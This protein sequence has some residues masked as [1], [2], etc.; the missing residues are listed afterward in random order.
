MSPAKPKKAGSRRPAQSVVAADG[1]AARLDRLEQA[2]ESLATRQAAEFAGLNDAIER[3][4]RRAS[5]P[6]DV[7]FSGDRGGEA[8]IL[9]RKYRRA[10]ADAERL[11][12]ELAEVRREGG[13]GDEAKILKRKYRRAQADA[14]QLRGE[15]AEARRELAAVR[16]ART[17]ISKQISGNIGH[18]LRRLLLRVPGVRKRL[19][20]SEQ[21]REIAIILGS[22]LFDPDWYLETY[23]DIAQ[24]GFDPAM[25]YLK[26]GWLETRDP[27][28]DFSTSGYLKANPDVA[29]SGAN[30]LL[31]YIE[32]GMGEGRSVGVGAQPQVRRSAEKFDPPA[33]CLQLPPPAVRPMQ[34]RRSHALGRAQ[35]GHV[36]LDGVVIGSSLASAQV[37]EEALDR[38]SR[39]ASTA[40]ELSPE[41][42]PVAAQQADQ[43]LP[44]LAD[45][46]FV[47]HLTM[48]MHWAGDPMRPRVVRAL[49]WTA[50][51]GLRLVGEGL[52]SAV[53]D[54]IDLELYTALHPL[55]LVFTSPNGEIVGGDV[56]AFPSLCRG[57]M[58]YA[59]LGLPG[60]DGNHFTNGFVAR[61][62]SFEDAWLAFGTSDV[63]PLLR[64]IQV[65]LHASDGSEP[66][67]QNQ[68]Q[69][70]LADIF[71]VGLEKP[72][73][74]AI[75]DERVAAFLIDKTAS[76]PPRFP[77]LRSNAPATLVLP[78]DCV[79]TIAILVSSSAD[80]AP[81]EAA[82]SVSVICVAEDAALGGLAAILP[83]ECRNFDAGKP[84]TGAI[85]WPQ[86]V[87]ARP[88]AKLAGG[89]RAG[90]NLVPEARLLEPTSRGTV[91]G[92]Q[93]PQTAPIS[94]VLAPDQW[95]EE[96]LAA[97]LQA[98][99][100]QAGANIVEIYCL[101]RGLERAAATLEEAASVPVQAWPVAETLLSAMQGELFFYIGGGVI[102]HDPR[103][104]AI[105]ADLAL[106]DG[107]AAAACPLLTHSRRGRDWSIAIEDAGAVAGE[108]GLV[109]LA[110][111]AARF[112]NTTLPLAQ[113]PS[114]LW[115]AR[116]STLDGAVETEDSLILTT[117]VTAS[118]YAP[119]DS[120]G[121]PSP[122]S[123]P[124]GKKA[125]QIARWLA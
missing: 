80:A 1:L 86:L 77:N 26:L 4:N 3:I 92:G 13:R 116:K 48:R 69:A 7:V 52:V 119:R 59:E 56:L 2:V 6:D 74:P 25:H 115:L 90:S 104:L 47:R 17:S 31:H 19:E 41:A 112:W 117:R 34:W 68:M 109:A 46:W 72:V 21:R 101:G 125:L 23:P 91:L 27:G 8:K 29:R 58:H 107:I 123:L 57:G 111:D 9:K 97:A 83:A 18:G 66:L 53:H 110:D 38:L 40:V 122:F 67:L 78:A 54:F 84:A 45:C 121:V 96:S 55:L 28:P 24:A 108:G 43:A 76:S 20:Q 11:R 106:S 35:G 62:R 75:G 44:R 85:F 120:V 79:P 10:Q 99:R 12:D 30:P 73:P 118:Y 70:W 33:P 102:L 32:H 49:Q 95:T 61:S 42:A 82:A 100:G 98:L 60:P 93:T 103:T 22:E 14:E 63:P 65:D 51:D 114:D 81:S 15:L 88:P 5:A 39:I 113:L 105:L 71:K 94:V 50:A 87:G 64:T 124:I 37:L 89:L 36:A 16:A